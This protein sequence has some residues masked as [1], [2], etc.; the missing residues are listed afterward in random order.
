[1]VLNF[2]ITA[3]D[4]NSPLKTGVKSG[5]N[6]FAILIMFLF[7]YKLLS[8]DLNIDVLVCRI[9]WIIGLFMPEY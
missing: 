3:F 6:S 7:I 8:K 5:L 9:L 2:S 1:M 4:N